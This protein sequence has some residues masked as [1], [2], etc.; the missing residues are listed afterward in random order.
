L[1]VVRHDPAPVHE[2]QIA[3]IALGI[4]AFAVTGMGREA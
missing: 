3:L 4:D 2:P 1:N